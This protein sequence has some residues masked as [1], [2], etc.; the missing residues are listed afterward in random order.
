MNTALSESWQRET[1]MWSYVWKLLHMRKVIFISGFRRARLRRKIGMT[2]LGLL[3]LGGFALV[4]TVSWF[5]L[6]FLRGPELKSIVG[7]VTPILDSVP[8]IILAGAFLGI[9]LTSFGVLLQALYLAGDMDFLLSAPIPVRAVFIAKLLQ[10]ILPNLGLIGLFSLPVL[11]GLGASGGYNILYYPLVLIILVSLALA[12][13]GLSSLLVLG[14]VRNF[15]ARRVAEVLAFVGATIS[16]LCSQ[17]GQFTSRMDF[18]NISQDQISRGLTTVS[19]FNSPW[20]P[21]AWAGRGLVDIGE[22]RWLTG[23]AFLI[24]TLGVAVGVFYFSLETAERLYYSGWAT[25]QVSTRKKRARRPDTAARGAGRPAEVTGSRPLASAVSTPAVR[26]AG[27]GNILLPADVRAIIRKD[28]LV[29]R[30]DL[31]NM[32]QMITPLI[33]GLIYA[34]ALLRNGSEIP[35]GGGDAPEVFMTALRSAFLYANVGISLFVGWSLLSRLAIQGFSQEGQQ[36]WILKSS[37]VSANKLLLAKFLVAFTPSVVLSLG[38][39]ALI[40]LLQKASLGVFLYGLPVVALSIA[41]VAG[42]N[43]AFGVRGA[44]LT[45]EDPRRMTRG[46]TGCL[47]TLVSLAFLGISLVLFFAPPLV[48][49]L[50][51]P[52]IDVPEVVG[53]GV[54]LVLGGALCL[55]ATILPPWL[56]RSRVNAIGEA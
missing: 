22:G 19:R 34:F 30:R 13:A 54:G 31:R 39:L 56:V 5:L 20:S 35:S 28:F 37:P 47:G 2:F 8:V 38:F 40:S 7:S 24:L 42:L 12:A 9:L 44:N 48:A 10:A 49:P 25:M 51:K 29:M 41:G 43:L 14:I 33:F 52:L 36:Y 55:T 32:S 1:S 6:R 21:L 4:F 3:V 18:S 53:Q 15:P 50:I 23:T 26:R 46:T 27:L 17:T 45:W 16:I 11:F